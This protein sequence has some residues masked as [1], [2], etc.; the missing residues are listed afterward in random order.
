LRAS[1][2]PGKIA[3]AKRPPDYEPHKSKGLE[4]SPAFFCFWRLECPLHAWLETASNA[5]IAT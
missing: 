2:K 3:K 4:D 5:I 1:S